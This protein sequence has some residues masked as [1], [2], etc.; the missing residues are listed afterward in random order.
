MLPPAVSRMRE[1]DM[2]GTIHDCNLSRIREAYEGV[3]RRIRRANRV[4]K[5][6]YVESLSESSVFPCFLSVEPRGRP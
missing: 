1:E 6:Q 3:T 5:M 4:A 2:P